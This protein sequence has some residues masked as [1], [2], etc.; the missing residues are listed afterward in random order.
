MDICGSGG[1]EGEY[2]SRLRLLHQ[3]MDQ[4]SGMEY[5]GL[6]LYK[7]IAAKRLS[8][9]DKEGAAEVIDSSHYVFKLQPKSLTLVYSS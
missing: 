5:E 8:R 9:G 3:K 6:Q 1:D 7:G 4:E 2:E